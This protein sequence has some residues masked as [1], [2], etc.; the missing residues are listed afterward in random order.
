MCMCQQQS[1]I[2]HEAKTDRTFKEKYINSLVQ[3]E[4]SKAAPLWID[5]E[6]DR[7]SRQK[8]SKDMVELNSTINHLDIIDISE[9]FL[10]STT[11]DYIF[12]SLSHG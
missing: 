3:L 2:V 11:A 12:F 4:A 9:L 5:Q 6:M 1:F 8:I 10:I 7:P